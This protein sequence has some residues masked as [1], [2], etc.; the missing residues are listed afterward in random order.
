MIE[1]IFKRLYD[2][3]FRPTRLPLYEKMMEQVMVH[4]YQSITIFDYFVLIQNNAIDINSKFLIIRH[5]IDTDPKTARELF[6]IEKK[7]GIKSTYYYRLKTASEDTIREILMHG[8]E[9][10]YH[11]EEIATYAK[12]YK[13]KSIGDNNRHIEDIQNLFQTNFEY[14]K[15]KY[16]TESRTVASHGDFINK[17]LK[18]PNY[19]LLNDSDFRKRLNILVEAYDDSFMKNVTCRISDLGK[20]D[21]IWTPRSFF[22]ALASNEHVLYVLIHP[23]QW[24]TRIASNIKENWTRFIEGFLYAM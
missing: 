15:R 8:G 7:Y 14:F 20:I 19:N 4:G 9:V 10:G 21:K 13:I 24:H 5:D 12:K 2:D 3:I 23:R 16:Q 11:Y 6:L 17:K 18:Y 1:R 22:D